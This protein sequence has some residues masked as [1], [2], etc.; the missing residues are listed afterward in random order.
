VVNWSHIWLPTEQKRFK[1]H[2]RELGDNDPFVA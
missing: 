1:V 2:G